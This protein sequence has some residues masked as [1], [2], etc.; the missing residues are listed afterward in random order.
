MSKVRVAVVIGLI[1]TCIISTVLAVDG[2]RSWLRY[3]HIDSAAALAE[4][5][6]MPVDLSKTGTYR[7]SFE[8]LFRHTCQQQFRLDFDGAPT[9]LD[10]WTSRLE[11][12]KATFTLVTTNGSKMF[13]ETLD[14]DTVI[15]VLKT[16]TGIVWASGIRRAPA[17]KAVY[18]VVLDVESPAPR[19]AG[20]SQFLISRYELCGLETMRTGI[21]GIVSTVF[22]AAAVVSA[23]VAFQVFKRSRLRPN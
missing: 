22:A 14:E 8:Q 10:D 16:A 9:A 23:F 21:L 1:L 6:R 7:G 15:P 13:S 18:Q 4:P 19:L 20:S 12:L 3:R 5:L 2:F 17:S 11:G